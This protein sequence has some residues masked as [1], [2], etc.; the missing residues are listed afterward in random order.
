M[1]ADARRNQERIFEE[2]RKA[3]GAGETDLTLN[4]L[5]RRAGVGVGT[6]YRLF[7]TH[8]AMLEAVV[9]DGLREMTD[10]ATAAARAEDATAGLAEFFRAALLRAVREPGLVSV[11]LA[12]DDAVT[13]TSRSKVELAAAVSLLLDRA[14]SAGAAQAALTGEDLLKLL[15]GLQHAIGAAREDPAAVTER[16]LTVVLTGLGLPTGPPVTPG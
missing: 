13:G 9:E 8:Q 3:I 16:Y 14:R 6:V 2:A 7:P 5:A 1:R 10:H 12:V 11:L 4:E 15:C